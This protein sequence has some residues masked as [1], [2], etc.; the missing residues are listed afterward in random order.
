MLI[1]KI[2]ATTTIAA[3]I[4]VNLSIYSGSL[5][6]ALLGSDQAMLTS[7]ISKSGHDIRP[8]TQAQ[9]EERAKGLTPEEAKVILRSGTEAPFC[10]N[11]ID[12]KL[13]GTYICRLC[14]LPLFKSDSKFKSGT[15]W[16]S[17]FQPVDPEHVTEIDDSTH[18]MTRTEIRC[19]RCTAHLGH[20]FPD[21]PEPTGLRF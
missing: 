1:T 4:I 10:G 12:N 13:D 16:P 5:S 2:L 6:A 21:G 17:F 11:L 3:M 14:A 15:G 9:I 8:L 19:T 7:T 20:V 18:G